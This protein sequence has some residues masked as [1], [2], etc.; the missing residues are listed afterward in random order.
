MRALHYVIDNSS[1]GVAFTPNPVESQM[2]SRQIQNSL[3][4]TRGKDLDEQERTAYEAKED[5]LYSDSYYS[6]M[7][8]YLLTS[9]ELES[10]R[11]PLHDEIPER[12]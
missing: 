8:T 10:L 6:E 9:E 5:P 11:V 12:A 2:V 7:E 4:S 1:A 3:Q